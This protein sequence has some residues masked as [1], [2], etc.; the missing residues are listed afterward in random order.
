MT[1]DNQPKL[2]PFLAPMILFMDVAIA[3]G[4]WFFRT[5]I[6]GDGPDTDLFAGLT[7][8]GLIGGAIVAYIVIGKMSKNVK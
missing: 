4:V 8:A 5:E 3:G 1:K 7:A 2:P 6:F